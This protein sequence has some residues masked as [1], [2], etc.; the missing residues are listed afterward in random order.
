LPGAIVIGHVSNH[1]GQKRTLM[2]CLA[3]WVMLLTAAYFI[4][5][6]AQF[7]YL[8]IGLGLVMGGT[9]SVSRSIM[10]LMTPERRTAEFFGFFNFSGRA[11]SWIGAFMFGA[12]MAFSDNA[13]LAI[14]SLLILFLIGW[15]IAATVDVAQGRRDAAQG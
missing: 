3:V 13:R 6:K 4:N 5:T 10:A 14:L 2:V 11:T 8:S 1:V 15:A 7:W 12:V 9:Q